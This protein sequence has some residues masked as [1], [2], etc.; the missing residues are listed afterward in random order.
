MAGYGE[1]IPDHGWWYAQTAMN[2]LMGLTYTGD[3][4]IPLQRAC[5][6]MSS[7]AFGPYC[8]RIVTYWDY[9]AIDQ[10][11]L[12]FSPFVATM[13]TGPDAQHL[14]APSYVPSSTLTSAAFTWDSGDDDLPGAF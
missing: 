12:A 13:T 2:T 4:A 8:S 5:A 11:T 7:S 3:A 10:A 14:A 1:L 6:V 9:T